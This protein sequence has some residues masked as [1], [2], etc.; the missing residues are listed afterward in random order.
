MK[1]LVNTS[2]SLFN[3]QI[4][5]EICLVDF[6]KKGKTALVFKQDYNFETV[7]TCLCK[8]IK[9]LSKLNF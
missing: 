9:Y 7:Q 3:L 8:C 5:T 2:T 6:T 1:I 4:A